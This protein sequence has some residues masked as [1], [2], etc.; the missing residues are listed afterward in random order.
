VFRSC[1][2]PLLP[3]Y[4]PHS[5]D[6]FRT[7]CFHVAQGA[8]DSSLSEVR[9]PQP[10]ATLAR[11]CQWHPNALAGLSFRSKDLEALAHELL[12]L[13]GSHGPRVFPAPSLLFA[14][15]LCIH[16]APHYPCQSLASASLLAHFA[17]GIILFANH[18]TTRASVYAAPRQPCFLLRSYL[19]GPLSY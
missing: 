3:S 17:P 1:W 16:T 5:G 18:A 6:G 19:I 12:I 9:L 7:S 10:P 13:N 11:E 15:D 4:Q 2:L 8:S 14:D